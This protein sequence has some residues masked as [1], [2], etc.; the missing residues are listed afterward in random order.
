MPLGSSAPVLDL[1]LV[2]Q[3]PGQ[4][5]V[6]VGGQ[7]VEP[8]QERFVDGEFVQ[9]LRADLPEQRD[10]VAPDLLPQLRIDGREQILGGLVP[11]PAQVDREPFERG[12]TIGQVCA[13]GEPAKGFHASQPY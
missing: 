6:Q 8:A 12:E 4:V 5:V 13:D 2:P 3:R 1:L 9:P 10:R 11:R 7:L